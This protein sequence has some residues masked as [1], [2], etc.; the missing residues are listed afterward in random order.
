MLNKSEI[1]K[2]WNELSNEDKQTLGL[3]VGIT[4]GLFVR[5]LLKR[6]VKRNELETVRLIVPKNAELMI[7]VKGGR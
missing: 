3:A 6:A 4:S 7:F 1:I 5:G 2:K